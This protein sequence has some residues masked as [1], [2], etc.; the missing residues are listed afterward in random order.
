MSDYQ[1]E[2]ATTKI[3]R[4]LTKLTLTEKIAQL[5]GVWVADL[6]EDGSLSVNR[7][8]ERIPH[9]IGHICQFGSTINLK[10]NALR[11]LVRK[12][13]TYLVE[14]SSAHL[15]AIFHDEAITGIA[16]RGATIYPQVIGMAA[17]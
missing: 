9:G 8:R 10:P 13:Q 7:C 3:A 16:A 15:P 4:L 5:Q 1:S 17:S 14:E 12:L 2:C 11:D 6:M